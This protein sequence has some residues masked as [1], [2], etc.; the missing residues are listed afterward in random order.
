[1]KKKYFIIL[2]IILFTFLTF[3]FYNDLVSDKPFILI[4]SEKT[5]ITSVLD[6]AIDPSKNYLYSSAMQITWNKLTKF[7][8]KETIEIEN[9]PKYIEKLNEHLNEPPN[10]SEHSYTAIACTN[11]IELIQ[12]IKEDLKNHFSKN[13]INPINFTGIIAYSSIYREFSFENKFESFKSK[14]KFS[15]TEIEIKSFGIE[16]YEDTEYQKKLANQVLI[17]YYEHDKPGYKYFV[18]E[19]KT[20]YS[21]DSIII[22]NFI[23][24]ETMQKSFEFINSKIILNATADQGYLDSLIIPKMNFNITHRYYDLINKNIKNKTHNN[25]IISDAMTNISFKIDESSIKFSSFF[26]PPVLANDPRLNING[27][28]FIYLI[29]KK[30]KTPY[31]MAYIGN[32]ELL[33]KK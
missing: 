2:A 10:I 15:S 4:S 20:N 7:F 18:F 25:L 1:M 5:I 6:Q 19:L 27:P 29:S 31:F 33:M 32:D 11:N 24:Q 8:F 17:H 23:P 12:K 26:E 30:C 22:S 16:K 28:F 13:L 3:Y 21:E 14:F 9:Q